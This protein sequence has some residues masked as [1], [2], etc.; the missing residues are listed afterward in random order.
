MLVDA[1]KGTRAPAFD[2]ERLAQG[3]SRVAGTT[4]G[5]RGLPFSVIRFDDAGKLAFSVGD[6][7]FVCD[8]TTYE[9]ERTKEAMDEDAEEV[10]TGPPRQPDPSKLPRTATRSPCTS[11][12]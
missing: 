8:L 10:R 4:Y 11:T 12:W 2:H 5:A 7:G 1:G 3:L 9:C 6:R